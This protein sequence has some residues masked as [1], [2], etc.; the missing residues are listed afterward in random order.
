MTDLNYAKI[1]I[2]TLLAIDEFSLL[3]LFQRRI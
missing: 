1:T 3:L 2:K